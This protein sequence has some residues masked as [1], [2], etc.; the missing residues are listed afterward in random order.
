MISAASA[1]RRLL[2]LTGVRWLPVG[3]M[4]SSTVLLPVERGMS[5][6]K[7][8]TLL[9][10]QGFI[11]LILELPSGALSDAFGRRPLLIGA[12]TLAIASSMLFLTANEYWMFALS[13]LIQGVFRALDS[14]SLESW[15]VDSMHEN[16]PLA[17][18]A[19]PLGWA[20]TVLGATIALGALVGG[21]LVAWAP[22][23]WLS[24][25]ALPVL[26]ASCCYV[27]YTVLVLCLV[28]EKHRGSAGC[29][30]SRNFYRMISRVSGSVV[31]GARLAA[32][33][34]VLRSLLFVEVFWALA[35]VGFETLT[36]L[37]LARILPS[38]EAAAAIYG[39]ASAAAWVCFALGALLASRASAAFGVTWV[40]I[41]SR[42]LNGAFVVL[43]GLAS[44]V[45]GVIAAYGLSYLANGA[46]GP[47]H[48]TL[49]HRQATPATR[50][51]IL[52]L[53]SMTS[54]GS[55]S[56]GL[57]LLTALAETVSVPV[58]IIVAGA[59]SLLG[60]LCYLP[61]LA[62]ERLSTSAEANTGNEA[63]AGD[64]ATTG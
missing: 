39:Q 56:L 28:R 20:S 3:I 25:L 38:E 29:P 52:S 21:L 13:F 22:V 30:R 54:G 63:N 16:N 55:Y 35:M 31:S 33:S 49:L 9:A 37:Q 45:I 61:A 5:I 58:A 15:F 12:G 57:L 50:A 11:V 14:G 36:P 44:G 59:L 7:L 1:Q 2:W 4:F 26:V 8:G 41:L 6:T 27:A 40:A 23:P 47:S 51:T 34:R 32:R 60:A 19:R 43:M 46:A 62:Q 17:N 10:M 24:P 48:A 53:N 18:I 64:G 42:L